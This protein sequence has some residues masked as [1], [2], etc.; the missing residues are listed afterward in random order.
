MRKSRS[1]RSQ[2]E[3]ASIWSIRL[4]L[5]VRWCIFLHYIVH[6]VSLWGPELLRSSPG[7]LPM[8]QLALPRIEY[9]KITQTIRYCTMRK[10]W[11]EHS[12]GHANTARDGA[13]ADVRRNKRV[14]HFLSKKPRSWSCKGTAKSATVAWERRAG[15]SFF[16]RSCF[17]VLQATIAGAFAAL[18]ENMLKHC[19]NVKK[20]AGFFLIICFTKNIHSGE[21]SNGLSWNAIKI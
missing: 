1:E 2:I 10:A 4:S 16:S 12:A 15:G 19:I 13:L 21:I 8:H 5:T 6:G 11:V 17:H 9:A 3:R 20:N 14:Q 7:P 18:G